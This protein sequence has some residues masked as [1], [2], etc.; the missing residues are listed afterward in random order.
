MYRDKD[1]EGRKG[2]EGGGDGEK[3]R[4]KDRETNNEKKE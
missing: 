4:D 3:E 2:E 1:E